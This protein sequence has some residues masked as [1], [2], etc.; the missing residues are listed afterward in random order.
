MSPDTALL[1]ATD[2]AAPRPIE[3][4]AP[5]TVT[6]PLI[7]CSPHSGSHY[8]AEFLAQS[9]LDAPV[10]RRSED[11]FVDE[12]FADV[13]AAGA[14]L[15]CALFPRAY[16]DPNREPFE[17]DPAM[18][19]DRL[20]DYVNTASARVAAGIGTIARVVANGSEIY[21]RKLRF[22]DALA[23]VERYWKPYHETLVALIAAAR[24][25]FGAAVVVDCHS[26]P[27]IGGPMDRD[28]GAKRVDIVLGDAYGAACHGAIVASAEAV[29]KGFGYQVARNM[30]Y[31]GAYTTRHYGRPGEGVHALQI[32]INRALYMDE[33]R[34]ERK[35]YFDTLRRHMAELIRTL[36]RHDPAELA[37]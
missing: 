31:A 18:F 35:A 23:R 29:L 33:E 30:P 3:V 36:A 25:R 27:S 8:A 11:S 15:L 22:G 17:L 37:P 10:L 16:I 14:P 6:A 1:A 28:P 2:L 24:A 4:R 34:Y 32:E 13:P 19:E 5:I 26:M 20:P 12:L 21:R 7:F 9:R